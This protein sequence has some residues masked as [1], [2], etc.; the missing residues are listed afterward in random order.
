M[1]KILGTQFFLLHEAK[2]NNES[3]LSSLF[4]LS[5]TTVLHEDYIHERAKWA[6]WLGTDARM[7]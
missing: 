6:C 5:R 1:R 2:N 7:P 4:V 3:V